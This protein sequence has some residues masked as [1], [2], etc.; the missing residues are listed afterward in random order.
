MEWLDISLA[1]L[2]RNAWA[3]VPLAFLVAAVCRW[4]PCR[5]TTRH[6]LW[7][8]VL[9]WFIVPVLLPSLPA[10]SGRSVS[11]SEPDNAGG[12]ATASSRL[13]SSESAN[14]LEAWQDSPAAARGR[15]AVAPDSTDS[16]APAPAALASAREAGALRDRPTQNSASTPGGE[17]SVYQKRLRSPVHTVNPALDRRTSPA[18]A[19]RPTTP[20][21]HQLPPAQGD[22]GPLSFSTRESLSTPESSATS[23]RA[24]ARP[25]LVREAA[26]EALLRDPAGQPVDAKVVAPPITTAPKPPPAAPDELRSAPVVRPGPITHYLNRWAGGLV[27]VRDAF[28]Q[29]PRPPTW[30]WI[31]GG[32]L[33]LSWNALRVLWF[34]FLTRHAMPA[35]LDIRS[36]VARL[37]RRAGLARPPRTVL[38]DA[39]MSP[40]V[41][42]GGRRAT[43]ILPRRLWS[44]LDPVGRRAILCHELAH[45]RRGDTWLCWVELAVSA[46]F[47]WHPLLWWVR[48]RIE[49]EADLCCD[50]WV[51]WLMPQGRRAYAEALLR[52][53]QYVSEANWPRP[54]VG[55]GVLSAGA[56]R[57]ARRLNMVMTQ[58]VRPRHSMTGLSLAG[59]VMLAGWIATP[60]WSGGEEC[61]KAAKAE[62]ETP[63][64]EVQVGPDGATVLSADRLELLRPGMAPRMV[65]PLRPA[66]KL[67]WP[68][69]ALVG[70]DEEKD[71]GGDDD[72]RGRLERLERRLDE[73]AHALH[74]RTPAPGAGPGS[75]AW[76]LV[77]P[78]GRFEW[79]NFVPAPPGGRGGGSPPSEMFWTTAPP[80]HGEGEASDEVVVESYALPEEK[81]EALFQLMVRDDVPIPVSKR[82]GAIEV[83]GNRRQ[84]HIMRAFIELIHPEGRGA[85]VPGPGAGVSVEGQRFREQLEAGRLFAFGQ[86]DRSEPGRV[87]EQVRK[88]TEQMRA[89]AKDLAAQQ[90]GL[91]KQAEKLRAQAAELEQ[92]AEKL[93]HEAEKLQEGKPKNDKQR[94]Q[95]ERERT[96][97]EQMLEEV[98]TQ[99][100][101]LSQA[102]DE[103]EQRASEVE[104]R[105]DEISSNSDEL[106]D[107]AQRLS[108]LAANPGLLRYA[109]QAQDWLGPLAQSASLIDRLSFDPDDS[110]LIAEL[111]QCADALAGYGAATT[112][113]AEASDE[114]ADTIE[115]DTVPAAS[116]ACAPA[117]A[118]AAAEATT[119]AAAPAAPA[120]AAFPAAPTPR[121]PVRP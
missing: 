7:V 110:E 35:P 44:D 117:P 24:P 54:A 47:W 98:E 38:L 121:E 22:R 62:V 48:R 56:K 40:L 20:A 102:A 6:A 113:E 114:D 90:H 18:A 41:W 17:P 100:E 65:A 50:A 85:H 12:A 109:A 9:L 52:T 106:S 93:R 51:T 5:A 33:L 116:P 94:R 78:D 61:E 87:A 28:S 55:L 32:L 8:L 64:V 70:H 118:P 88:L 15:G 53:N 76:S 39:R 21:P 73:L 23:A 95:Q 79:R 107:V 82:D 19:A 2:W 77:G 13:A 83:H 46:L 59:V 81:L 1:L 111:S 25:A 43:L 30:I 86:A 99:I 72:V 57:I 58:Q 105:L 112:P 63:R 75:G 119:P 96:S 101:Q 71:E 69:L 115:L 68:A 108:Q 45:I 60:A 120:P 31:L 42:C 91:Q 89:R 10:P 27:A 66:F 103:V 67:S 4:A 84:Q 16:K 34:L 97:I 80:M 36:E 29:L 3:V 104:E 26:S 37:A 11:T 92:R 14:A 74:A 49:E